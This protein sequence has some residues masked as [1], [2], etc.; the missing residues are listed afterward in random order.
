MMASALILGTLAAAVQVA[1]LSLPAEIRP[2]LTTHCVDCHEG[3]RAKG[4]L[5]LSRALEAG[6]IE[7][8]A[9]RDI[10]R[11]L[12]R[13]DMPPADEPVR[14]G[15]DE[16]R[17]AVVAIDLVAPPRIREV[18]VARRLNR[19]QY[20]GAVRD[21]LGVDASLARELLPADEIGEGFDTTASTLALPPLLIEKYLDAAERIAEECVPPDSW[22]RM[23]AVPAHELE[24]AGPGGTYD[25]VAWLASV[26]TLG[27][28][29]DVER[30]GRFAVIVDACGQFA[31]DED[32]RLAVLVDG[33]IVA[34][35][36]ITAPV[37]SRQTVSLEVDFEPGNHAVVA[38]F[39]NDFW[40]PKNEDPKR[41]DRNLGI[42]RIAIEG[43]LGP[44]P[45]TAFERRASAIGGEGA[46]ILRL[47]RVAE[48]FGEE[49]FR[50]P[51]SQ[52]EANALASTAREGAGK[53][54]AYDAQLRTLV[55]A[56]LADPRFLLRVELPTDPQAVGRQP[57]AANDLAS[58]LAFFL[59]SS[60]P[61]AELRQVA[62]S[63]ALAQD[64]AIVAQVRRMLADPRARSLSERFATQW[65]GIDGL[66]TR[67]LDPTLFPGID[68]A[69]LV[70]MRLE[71]EHLFHRI[72]TGARP[73]R[74]LL[75]SRT[76]HVDARLAAH[77]G[78]AVPTGDA[79]EPREVDPARGSGVLGHA[80][81][82]VAT[83][84]P[85]RTSPVKRGKWVLQAILDDAPPPPP[86]GV[87]QLPEQGAAEG[88]AT[89]RELMALHRA[90]PDCASCHVRM[91]AFGLAFESSAPDGRLRQGFDDSAELPDGSILR[92]VS[93]LADL[94]ARNRAFERSIA[95]QLLVYALGR[96]TSEADEPLI[97]ALAA[98]A[99][100]T[101]SF[102]ALVEGI[103][104]SDA[105][106]T[107]WM[108]AKAER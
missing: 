105:F 43:P 102:A 65:L 21:V 87:P 40:D 84:N 64:E 33:Q 53:G 15:D 67:Q 96:G 27:A 70:S 90:N 79:W 52:G 44:A 76:T 63:G 2:L 68:G 99:A 17:A 73:L 48:R 59:W 56:L 66:E 75:E 20:A 107:R 29:F 25:G 12:A 23:R 72:V 45:A 31:G 24:R 58:R 19:A 28:R 5:D 36:S 50:R 37:G 71:T 39:T 60:V 22:S 47:R 98:R 26:G 38:R 78:L 35:A 9:L 4:G 8:S 46:D 91:D 92:G 7:E 83:S 61:D 16:Y 1:E 10:R 30:G 89:I 86:P 54:A 94:L 11:R 104:L 49:L 42:A 32:P 62:Q 100:E 55:T 6:R 13:R 106:R 34:E 74:A 101:G 95:R 88:G 81:V 3:A 108:L 82:L 77:Y 51:L 103:V 85:T 97:D 18:A 69:L 80:S 14:P 93:G 41:R 57:I